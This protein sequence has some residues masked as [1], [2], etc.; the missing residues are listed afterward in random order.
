MPNDT[1]YSYS[2]P[3]T[4][5]IYVITCH[6][7]TLHSTGK[8]LAVILHRYLVNLFH[9]N[10]LFCLHIAVNHFYFDTWYCP[11]VH[12]FLKDKRKYRRL[13][14]KHKIQ[15]QMYEATDDSKIHWKIIFIQRCLITLLFKKTSYCIASIL[16]TPTMKLDTI[17]SLC[18][19]KWFRT[20]QVMWPVR[21][22][23]HKR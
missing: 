10:F 13:G 7:K 23:L 19:V 18:K 2:K 14:V 12:K 3:Q 9:Y 15:I 11:K 5:M 20:M 16:M 21:H 17:F 1:N 4:V 22:F 8:P 6:N